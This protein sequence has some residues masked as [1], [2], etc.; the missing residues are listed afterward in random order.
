MKKRFLFVSFLFV[1]ALMLVGCGKTVPTITIDEVTP[2]KTSI[3]FVVNVEDSDEIGEIKSVE[4]YLGKEKVSELE[5]FTVFVFNDL[6]SNREYKI[7]VTYE[8]AVGKK[9]DLK[10]TE[11][12]VKT[13][14]KATP[15]YKIADLIATDDFISFDFDVT[16][17]DNVGEIK[18]VELYSG[19][20]LVQTLTDL[21][22]KEFTGLAYN[23]DYTLVV[24]YTYDLNDGLGEV[25]KTIT[26]IDIVMKNPTFN[27]E[28][29]DVE[30]EVLFA[31]VIIMEK[32]FDLVNS[33]T[34]HE[35]I[36]LN[37]S[38]SEYGYF[39]TGVCGLE[40]NGDLFQFWS[41]KVNGEDSM[42]GISEVEVNKGDTIS[43]VLTTWQ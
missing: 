19:I 7:K 18:K 6:L 40:A 27:V 34:I 22:V 17:D 25:E 1:L 41:L 9:L 26:S 37:G 23:K 5:S 20:E 31:G 35:E 38:T 4:L 14:G 24:I 28:V 36:K 12:A 3:S 15:T 33:L 42:V 10:I 43:F 30:G 13:L 32:E 16:D 11:K 29:I 2:T 8:Y 39:V 21:S